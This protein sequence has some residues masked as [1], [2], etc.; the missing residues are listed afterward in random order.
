MRISLKTCL[1]GLVLVLALSG[2]ALSQGMKPSV[3][4][5]V[6]WKEATPEM[7]VAYLRGM[8]NMADYEVAVSGRGKAG[9]LSAGL[10]DELKGKSIES[11]VKDV[12]KFYKENA[13]KVNTPVVE[14]VVRQCT[15]L[16]KPAAPS[17]K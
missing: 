8:G 2:V 6:Q 9:C 1:L 13:D 15:S 16:C 17:K 10:V 12:D 7:K 11:I 4:T 3:I 14:V 5:G